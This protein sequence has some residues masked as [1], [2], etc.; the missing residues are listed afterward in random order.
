MT[1][2]DIHAGSGTLASSVTAST[3]CGI[4]TCPWVLKAILGQQINITLIDFRYGKFHQL[5]LIHDNKF[6][7]HVR[8]FMKIMMHLQQLQVSKVLMKRRY[9]PPH[10]LLMWLLKKNKLVRLQHFVLDRVREDMCTHPLQTCWRSVLYKQIWMTKNIF[11]LNTKVSPLKSIK[12]CVFLQSLSIS[13][14]KI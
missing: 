12:R 4:S 2:V 7:T 6:D 3:G 9:I 1:S 8:V 13:I 11:S 5:D 14:S 10:V